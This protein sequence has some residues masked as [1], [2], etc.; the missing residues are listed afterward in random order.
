MSDDEFLKFQERAS[1]DYA[2]ERVAAG[3]W[4]PKVARERAAQALSDLL[5]QGRLSVGHRMM[6]LL[7]VATG[8]AVGV[9]WWQ[10]RL[11]GGQRSAQLLD[12]Y[13]ELKHRGYG[14]G[15]VAMGM[16]EAKVRAEGVRVLT[17]NVFGRNETAIQLYRSLDFEVISLEMAKVL[18]E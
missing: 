12:L 18:P 4:H 8:Q 7:D 11:R 1:A 15:R 17:L 2:A 5:P 9:I 16:L 10:E 6:T 14:F 3:D 13:I